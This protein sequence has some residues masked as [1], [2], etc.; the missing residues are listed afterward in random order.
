MCL[1]RLGFVRRC[2]KRSL[3]PKSFLARSQTGSSISNFI[4]SSLINECH[5]MLG[6]QFIR[7][8]TLHVIYIIKLIFV[9]QWRGTEVH[10]RWIFLETFN[11]SCGKIAVQWNHHGNNIYNQIDSLEITMAN[12]DLWV[13]FHPCFP[14]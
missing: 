8:C 1:P 11:R 3:F 14:F 13:Q 4:T 12:S 6:K 5:W 9:W 7:Y 2:G 10:K